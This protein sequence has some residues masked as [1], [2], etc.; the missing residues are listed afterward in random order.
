MT[1]KYDIAILGSGPGGYV[2]ALKAAQMKKSVALIEKENIGGMCLNWGCIPSKSLLKSAKVYDSII[3]SKE[4]GIDGI[5][6]DKITLNWKS[7]KDRAFKVVDKLTSGVKFL[8]DKNGVQIYKGFGKVVDKNKIAVENEIIEFENLIIATGSAYENPFI[9]DKSYTP[10]NIYSLEKLPSSLAI[11]GGGLIGVEFA[12]LFSSLGVNVTLFEAKD[13]LIPFMDNDIITFTERMLK[14]KK[15]KIFLQS[16]V[17]NFENSEIIFESNGETKKE[18]AEVL[19]SAA[20]RKASLHGL[21]FLLENGLRT[22]DGYIKTDLRCRTSLPNVYAIGD[23]N[24][25]WMLAHVAS[26]EAATAVETINGGG[27][28]LNYEMMPVCLYSDPEIS[29]AGITE[30]TA[31]KKGFLVETGKFPLS[32]NGKALAEGQSEGFVKIVSDKKYGEILGVHIVADNATDLIGE[33]VLAMQME[34]TVYDIASV[35][36]AHPTFS[37]TI[38]EATLKG[39]GKPLHTL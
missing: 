3:K 19:L 6:K 12:F 23:V 35:V 14:K 9:S 10:K 15:V 18:K 1:K 11:A 26:V 28:D 5:E 16:E 38:L 4:F 21:E 39:L 2:A 20:R 13:R 25:L 36:H 7:M 32:A 22:E 17:K 31:L 34:G 27:S 30:Q 29:C 33:S 8:L 24:G 37:E